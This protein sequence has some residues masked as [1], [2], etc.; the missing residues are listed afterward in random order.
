MCDVDFTTL[1]EYLI[2]LNEINQ[3]PRQDF[4]GSEAHIEIVHGGKKAI[5]VRHLQ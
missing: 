2:E 1:I 3:D 4:F 5:F